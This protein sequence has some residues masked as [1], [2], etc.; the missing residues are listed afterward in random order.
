MRNHNKCH[1]QGCGKRFRHSSNLKRHLREKPYKCQ[2]KGR[3][4]RFRHSGSL[5]GPTPVRNHINAST[6]AVLR[7]FVIVE[8]LKAPHH[9]NAS[10]KAVLRDFVIVE[11]LKAPHPVQR[12]C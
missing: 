5:E 6:K 3:A 9:I 11:V 4:K 8:V 12:L 7:D 2:Y 10:T 1:H